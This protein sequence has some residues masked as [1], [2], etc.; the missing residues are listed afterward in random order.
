[1]VL[2]DKVV[3]TDAL[4]TLSERGYDQIMAG[5]EVEKERA[6]FKKIIMNKS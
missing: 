5:D 4:V 2:S 3:L 6:Y 1:M